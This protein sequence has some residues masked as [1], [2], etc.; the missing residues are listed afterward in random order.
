MRVLDRKLVRDLGRMRGQVVTIALVV[1]CGIAAFVS[2]LTTYDS[3][4][5]SQQ[6]YYGTSRFAQVF[7]RLERAPSSLEGRIREI[8]GVA[9]VE[10]RLV[11]DVSLDAGGS[12]P[13]AV[14]RMVSVPEGAQPRLNALHLR[15]GRLV[16]PGHVDEV[17][18][19]E[20]FA[21]FHRL[22]PGDR[23][24]AVLNGRRQELRVAGVALSPEYVFAIRGGDP[25]PD[26]RGFAVV[27]TSRVGLEAAFD[28]AG[29]F[30]DVALTLA[31]GTDERAVIDALDRLL[32]P[33][34][35]AGAIA[36]AEQPSH[37]FIEDEIRQNQTM[38]TTIPPIFLAVAAFLLNVVLGRLVA[39]QREQIAAMKA[40]GY[41][42]ATIAL[43]YLK[44]V[45]VIVVAGTA[46]GIALGAALGRLMLVAYAPFVRMPRLAYHMTP[47]IPVLAAG[48]GVVAG[49]LGAYGALR[50]VVALAPAE[51]MR[52]PAPR[53]YHRILL[54]RVGARGWLGPRRRMAVRSISGH[55][56][57][58]LLTIT[59]VACATAI[60]VLSRWSHDAVGFM[61]DAQFRLA[62]RGDATI[63]FVEPVSLRAVREIAALPGVLRAEG[64]RAVA[65]RLRAG[66]HTYRTAILGLT[67]DAQLR[68]LL[69]AR[70]RPV[71]PPPDGILLTDRLAERLGVK[72]GDEIVAEILEGER[73][74]PTVVVVGSVNDMIGMS[75]YMDARALA[76]LL[77][78]DEHASLAA[79]SVDPRSAA[80][81]YARLKNVGRV[82]TVT[83]KSA[84][85]RS[86]ED[87]TASFILVFTAILTS[88]A[89]V[90]A[91]GVV[92]N[93]ARIALQE[94]AWE[95][96]SLRVLGF[97]RAEVSRILL[98]EI[99]A[100]LVAAL[101]PGMWL[102]YQA[103]T[104]LARLHETE[105]FRIPVIVEPATYAWSAIVVVAAGV[106]SALIVRRR[107]DRLDLVGVLKARE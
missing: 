93:T 14:G 96:A 39:T 43:H 42:N 57:R 41:A 63:A 20:G 31:P 2:S 52:P 26:D 10:T 58:T 60:V 40:V 13:P 62:E 95:L 74:K 67:T 81:L 78:E 27:W 18:V 45:L 102:G 29:A 88:F 35:G 12:G 83:E 3:L 90:I 5:A 48:V 51:A 105:M 49:V 92:Y 70:L 80:A 19:S 15:A 99:G 59:G 8:A 73:T 38:A 47:W 66:H 101:P 76:R 50:S 77:R 53:V 106:G 103:S 100:Q 28:M 86:F 44:L 7:A 72:P 64:Q 37:R 30:N 98:T 71:A 55:P 61:L 21:S 32:E 6:A 75:G 46:V 4:R 89:V 84:A 36:R 54:E 79:I 65:V 17:L 56:V 22:H 24:T 82:A 69:D 9:Q 85:L 34:G 25:L 104:G 11:F 1:A 33:Y 97:T 87:T 94:R 91:I 23:L 107:I 16:E 68:R